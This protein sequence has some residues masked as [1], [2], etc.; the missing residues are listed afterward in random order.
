MLSAEYRA[1]AQLSSASPACFVYRRDA[2]K[3]R[4][5][6]VRPSGLAPCLVAL[7]PYRMGA[8]R[9]TAVQRRSGLEEAAEGLVGQSAVGLAE[10]LG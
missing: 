3:A 1:A 10:D 5:K 8:H 6:V 4:G 7:L 9:L 2:D